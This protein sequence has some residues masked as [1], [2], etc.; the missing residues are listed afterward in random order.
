METQTSSNGTKFVRRSGRAL[1]SNYLV[2]NAQNTKVFVGITSKTFE[3]DDTGKRD[4]T[5]LNVLDLVTNKPEKLWV[6][7]QLKH[8]LS[9]LERL[10]GARLEITWTGL[11]EVMDDTTGEVR[12]INS[13]NV[14]E[15]E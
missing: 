6:G 8:T 15:L 7:G 2:C 9:K 14:F 10:Q 11:N 4:Q 12:E 1:G 5:Y 13:Y 3:I